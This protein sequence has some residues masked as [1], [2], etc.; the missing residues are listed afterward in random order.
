M[1]HPIRLQQFLDGPWPDRAA[2]LADLDG[3]LVSGDTVLPEVPDL[4]K[5]CGD[6]LWIV[7]NNS[8]DTAQTLSARLGG[9]GLAPPYH[10]GLQIQPSSWRSV[11]RPSP[12]PYLRLAR[13][14]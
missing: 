11:I 6:R 8:T 7:S 1:A 13:R 5:R 10:S 9:L 4:F 14:H 12:V 2:I 3:C